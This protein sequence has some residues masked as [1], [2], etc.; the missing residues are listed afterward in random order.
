LKSEAPVFCGPRLGP[1]SE[2]WATS[3]GLPKKS[4]ICF[5]DTDGDLSFDAII[6]IGAV[7]PN[8]TVS[9]APYVAVEHVPL[10]DSHVKIFYKGKRSLSKEKL[11]FE[12]SIFEL[13]RKN[14]ETHITTFDS[15]GNIVAYNFHFPWAE[16]RYPLDVNLMGAKFNALQLNQADESVII[17][18]QDLPGP[19]SYSTREISPTIVVY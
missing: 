14:E 16:G 2:I 3:L 5:A 4:A 10:S 15:S 18:W 12:I 13:G 8:L 1:Q 7:M 17:R 11:N 19:L 6:P 9:N